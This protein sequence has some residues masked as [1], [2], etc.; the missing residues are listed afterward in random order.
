M[1]I[2]IYGKLPSHGDFLRRRV[3]DEFVSR[4]DPWLQQSIAASRRML[5]E[6]W[7][8]TYLTSPVWRFACSAGVLGDAGVAGILIPSVDRVGRYFPLS[9]VWE[10]PEH[11]SLC[12]AAVQTRWFEE[13]E[14]HVVQM[15]EREDI[16]FEAFDAGLM[17]LGEL[18]AP[19]LDPMPV[20][21][22]AGAVLPVMSPARAAW[23]LPL[24]HPRNLS[25]LFAEM[26]HQH[27][28]GALQPLSLW[29]TEGSELVEPSCLMTAGLPHVEAF[30]A[31]LDGAWAESGWHSV[32]GTALG[33]DYLEEPLSQASEPQLQVHSAAFSDC[34]RV[35]S[36]N[37]DAFIERL[38]IG[39]WA[40]ADGMGG[41]QGG[42]L[43]SR[44]VCDALADLTPAD[45]LPNMVTAVRER[46]QQVNTHLRG[47]HPGASGEAQCGTTVVAML[48][49]RTRV[50]ILWAGDSRAYRLRGVRLEQ[51]TRDHGDGEDQMTSGGGQASFVITRAVGCSEVLE[52]DLH[53]DS[54]QQGDRF[55]LCSDGLTHELS[56]GRIEE[57]MRGG[58]SSEC[59]SALVQAALAAGGSDN[60]TALV[61]DA[62]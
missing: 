53:R 17:S 34:G 41:H 15:L 43:A 61:V 58:S 56:D 40:V 25:H 6:R 3:S 20:S 46:L 9:I 39:L 49:R 55:L 35:R 2:G 38:D 8:D 37:Q 14:A 32:P 60:V 23:R 47:I 29:W 57:L 5:G 22:P 59:V 26:L 52:L 33:A 24:G 54:V 36:S 1:E 42:D 30:A 10:I 45:T 16:D 13:T 12:W 50:A 4:W 31:F 19:V 27:L 11:I 7:L 44:A 62:F 28:Q 21:L 51:L 48:A 18:L